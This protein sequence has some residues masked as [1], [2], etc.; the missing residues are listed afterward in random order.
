M[1]KLKD[2]E[3]ELKFPLLNC[4]ELIKKLNLIAKFEEEGKYQKDTYYV[5]EHRNFLER[6]PVSEWLRIRESKKGSNLN[7]KKW[8]NEKDKTVSCDEFEIEI[9]DANGL[10][11][12]FQS[13]DFREIVVVEKTRNTWGYKDTTI[14]VDE[15]KNLGNFIEIEAKGKFPS[16]TSAKQHLY[17]VLKEIGVE[18]GEQDF[19]GYPYLLLKKKGLLK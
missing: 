2:I 1:D 4:Q 9:A 15:V 19:E 14:A 17:S 16:V 5:P 6:K 3:I 7:Y 11:K 12:I 8:H 13:L 18:V 10:K